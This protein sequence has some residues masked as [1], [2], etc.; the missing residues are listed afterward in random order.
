MKSG[1]VANIALQ[2]M[3]KSPSIVFPGT[4]ANGKWPKQKRV[5]FA[6]AAYHYISKHAI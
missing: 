1:T 2:E 4:W 5:Q 6:N 3:W